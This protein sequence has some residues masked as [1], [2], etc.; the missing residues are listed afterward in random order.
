M[1]QDA[2]I[3]TTAALRTLTIMIPRDHNPDTKGIR[4][5]DRAVEIGAHNARDSAIVSRVFGPTCLRMVSRPTHWER[6]S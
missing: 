1:A 6:I 5:T 4:E 2:N 3:P